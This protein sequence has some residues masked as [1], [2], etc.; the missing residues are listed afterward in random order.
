MMQKLD[1]LEMKNVEN[2]DLIKLKQ[3]ENF[4]YKA[5]DKT[6]ELKF[7]Q[8]V[9]QG[10]QVAKP[11]GKL[12]QELKMDSQPAGADEDSEDSSLEFESSFYKSSKNTESSVDAES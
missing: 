3:L 5:L 7:V 8:M 11:D 6:K 9:S 4:L 2:L 10:V 12:W 1:L